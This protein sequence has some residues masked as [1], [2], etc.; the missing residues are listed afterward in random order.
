MPWWN[1]RGL[2]AAAKHWQ[3]NI[4]LMEKFSRAYPGSFRVVRYEDLVNQPRE[5]LSNIMDYLGEEFQPAQINTD[6]QSNLVLPRST[7][8]KGKAL[9]VIDRGHIGSRISKARAE[10]LAFLTRTMRDELERYGYEISG[11]RL[12]LRTSIPS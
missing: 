7:E 8:W 3:Q 10:E 11:S 12:P 1:K 2:R 9:E 4:Q 5:I 6:V